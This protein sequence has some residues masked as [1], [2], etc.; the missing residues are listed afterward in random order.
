MW[1]RGLLAE[2]GFVQSEPTL[3]YED[4]QGTLGMAT[5]EL[6]SRRTRGIV[7]ECAYVRDSL[8][9]GIIRPYFCSSEHMLADGLTKILGRVLFDK[10]CAPL[11][12][13]AV[14][15]VILSPYEWSGQK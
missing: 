5:A 2:L 7:L 10:H 4:N 9:R 3:V 15:P 13:H 12:G 1:L 14:H 8:R 11:L 6:L